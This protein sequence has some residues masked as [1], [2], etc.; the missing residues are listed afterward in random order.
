MCAGVRL[1]M[2]LKRNVSLDNVLRVLRSCSPS[3]SRRLLWEVCVKAPVMAK[4]A[5]LWTFSIA[6]YINVV[7][8]SK[9]TDLYSSTGRINEE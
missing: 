3:L 6:S 4:A 1:L 5:C 8:L 9:M 2:I 7:Q